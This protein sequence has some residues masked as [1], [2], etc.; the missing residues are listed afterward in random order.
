MSNC[1]SN[2]TGD[3]PS[4]TVKKCLKMGGERLRRFYPM[5]SMFALTAVG[6]IAHGDWRISLIEFGIA[7]Y[8]FVAYILLG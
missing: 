4:K 8:A 5:V 3:E 7:A 2:P 1:S 6:F